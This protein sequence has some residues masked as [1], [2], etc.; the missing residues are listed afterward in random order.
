MA[1]SKSDTKLTTVWV[2]LARLIYRTYPVTSWI[3]WSVFIC[4]V[5]WTYA[6]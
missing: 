6:G 4:V 2:P 1:W 3:C 5:R